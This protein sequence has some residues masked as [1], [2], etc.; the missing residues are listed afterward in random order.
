MSVVEEYNPEYDPAWVGGATV[1][2]RKEDFERK[3][4]PLSDNSDQRCSCRSTHLGAI[5]ADVMPEF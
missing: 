1:K 4:D 3:D 5:I 2:A